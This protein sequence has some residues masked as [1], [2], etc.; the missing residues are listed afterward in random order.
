MPIP[1]PGTQLVNLSHVEDLA[2]MLAAVPGNDAA[3]RQHFNLASDRAITFDGG[4]LGLS[5]LHPAPCAYC[6]RCIVRWWRQWCHVLL[7]AQVT[8][9]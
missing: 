2:E 3:V 8:V 7:G 6:C 4:P 9:T 1:S 5:D